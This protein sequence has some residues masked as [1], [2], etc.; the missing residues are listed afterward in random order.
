M[1]I[2]CPSSLCISK[3]SIC[4][5]RQCSSIQLQLVD[6]HADLA[7]RFKTHRARLHSIIHICFR[8]KYTSTCRL[9]AAMLFKGQGSCHTRLMQN[10]QGMSRFLIKNICSMAGFE[11]T[12]LWACPSLDWTSLTNQPS[13]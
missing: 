5:A 1:K 9:T 12:R 13:K 4:C 3:H 6:C 7:L 11:P 10:Q 2:E 8:L